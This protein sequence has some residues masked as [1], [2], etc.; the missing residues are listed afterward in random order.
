MTEHEGVLRQKLDCF[1][2]S[3]AKV[4]Q[5]AARLSAFARLLV[6]SLRD[7]LEV[8]ILTK[9]NFHLSH[10]SAKTGCK[11]AAS[12]ASKPPKALTIQSPREK[13]QGGL[14]YMKLRLL[15][16]AGVRMT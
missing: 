5:V 14:A 7:A 12:H 1:V 3:T 16:T 13:Q 15:L 2:L 9:S 8:P 10:L 4:Q 11:E 6:I